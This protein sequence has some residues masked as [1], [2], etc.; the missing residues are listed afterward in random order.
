M[1]EIIYYFNPVRMFSFFF[2]L[3]DIIVVI[4]MNIDRRAILIIA[5]NAFFRLRTNTIFH[6]NVVGDM[7][8]LLNHVNNSI[9]EV[10]IARNDFSS[11]NSNSF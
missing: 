8:D 5:F 7:L 11:A 9:G 1:L 3:E 4:N 10:S 2:I 6:S